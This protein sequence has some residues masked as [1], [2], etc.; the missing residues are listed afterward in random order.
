LQVEVWP[1]NS[2][3]FG[4]A[5]ERTTDGHAKK[6]SGD[7]ADDDVNADADADGR[8]FSRAAISPQIFADKSRFFSFRSQTFLG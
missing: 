4:R 3:N 6:D 7:V 8:E 2:H 1:G 5:D